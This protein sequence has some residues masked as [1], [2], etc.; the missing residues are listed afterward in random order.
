ML[1]LQ[2]T[3]LLHMSFTSERQWHSTMYTAARGGPGPGTLIE[4]NK[5]HAL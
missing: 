4:N 1:Q 3:F 2:T 5:G